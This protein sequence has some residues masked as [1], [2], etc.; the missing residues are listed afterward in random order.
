MISLKRAT[1]Y[2][3]RFRSTKLR[4]EEPNREL[5]V[6]LEDLVRK[7]AKNCESV[8][9]LRDTLVLE[10]LMNTLPEDVRIFV[11]E[12]KPRSSAEAGALANDFV[13]ARR[14]SIVEPMKD[15]QKGEETGSTMW[16]MSKIG[17]LCLRLSA[18]PRSVEG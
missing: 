10:Q 3:K 13:A 14:E 15:D 4:E 2:R 9:E 7:W 6:R 18:R 12:R 1:V 8:D 16:A 17:P 5:V 11:R